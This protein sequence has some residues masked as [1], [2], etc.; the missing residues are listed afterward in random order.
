MPLKVLLHSLRTT[1]QG[2]KVLPST[3]M[4]V[5]PLALRGEGDLPPSPQDWPLDSTLVGRCLQFRFRVHLYLGLST[6][7]IWNFTL[8][9]GRSFKKEQEEM[10]M[11]SI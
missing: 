4:Y 1:G 6:S 11:M 3:L 9:I 10:Q 8:S 2:Q 5:L 7:V